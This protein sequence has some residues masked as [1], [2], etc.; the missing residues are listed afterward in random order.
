MAGVD[1]IDD[2]AAAALLPPIDSLN[3]WSLI[4]GHNLTSPRVEWPITPFGEDTKREGCSVG[5][6]PKWADNALVH[7]Y[8]HGGRDAAYMADGRYKLLVGKIRQA[9]WCG[10]VHPNISTTWNSFETIENCSYPGK[11]GACSM[12]SMTKANTT[13][14]L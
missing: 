1:P 13:I 14:C 7:K 12:F 2:H 11:L 10:Q 3:V 9:G 5:R 8:W 4:S 6:V